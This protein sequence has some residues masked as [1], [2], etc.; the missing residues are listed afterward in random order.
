MSSSNLYREARRRDLRHPTT[1]VRDREHYASTIVR[2]LSRNSSPEFQ[3]HADTQHHV[4]HILLSILYS[5][6]AFPLTLGSSLAHIR[7]EV[8]APIDDIPLLVLSVSASS[9]A[10]RM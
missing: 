5:V 3:S 2:N 7:L 8:D 4:L 9:A 6:L 10:M 1:A